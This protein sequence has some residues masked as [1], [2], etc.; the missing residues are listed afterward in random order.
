MIIN[1]A[2][3]Q[4]LYTTLSTIFNNAFRGH[5]LLDRPGGHDRSER[6]QCQDYKAIL[7]WPQMQE[8]IG[9]RQIRSV[10][11]IDMDVVNKSYESSVAVLKHDIQDDQFGLYNPLIAMMATRAKK[12]R[13]ILLAKLILNGTRY[14]GQTFLPPIRWG[15]AP[16]PT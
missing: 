1:A 11:A 12:H 6:H 13:D 15:W 5:P 3:M 16:W 2:N 7:D 10:E 8:W 14:D 4:Y 9:D